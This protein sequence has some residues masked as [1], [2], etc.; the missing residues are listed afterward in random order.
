MALFGLALVIILIIWA[1]IQVYQKTRLSRVKGWTDGRV[2]VGRLRSWRHKGREGARTYV[3]ELDIEDETGRRFQG[4][5]VVPIGRRRLDALYPG[6]LLPIV[7]RPGFEQDIS[8]PAYHYTKRAQLFYDYVC[9]R[10]GLTDQYALNADYWGIPA[11][12]RITGSKGTGRNYGAAYQYEFT[13][14]VQP[15]NGQPFYAVSRKFVSAYEHRLLTITGEV[16]VKF[17]PQAPQ[18]V[19]FRIPAN[20]RALAALATAQA[21]TQMK[22]KGL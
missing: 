7:Y 6:M 8:L 10:E 21:K 20:T 18:V 1:G 22:Q 14:V 11:K 4:H 3:L 13:L 15:P 9:L 17:L 5:V 16:D 12:G 2:G 19:V